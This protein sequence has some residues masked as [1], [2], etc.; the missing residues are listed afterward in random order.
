[1]TLKGT[2]IVFTLSGGSN[3]TNPTMSWGGDPS[4]TPVS[5]S[6][7]NLFPDV[8]SDQ[9]QNGLVDYSCFYVFNNS[10]AD[11]L[12]NANV[13]VSTVVQ[14]GS[15]VMIGIPVVNEIQTVTLTGPYP[16]SGSFVLSIGGHN[17]SVNQNNDLSVWAA[18]FQAAIRAL[19]NDMTDVVVTAGQI[20]STIVFTVFF[21]GDAGNTSQPLLELIQNNLG[22]GISFAFAK[23]QVGSPINLITTSIE[24]ATTAPSGIAFSFPTSSHPISIGDLGPTE[25][26]PV[27]V[28][29]T[30]PANT[31]ALSTDGFSLELQGEATG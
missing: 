27:W 28:Q 14:G 1:M 26:F 30:T 8:T 3:N 24:T 21:D 12:Y 25:G 19:P 9:A 7:N 31:A 17:F 18:N 13:W 10:L 5:Q 16:G 22:P 4:S 23:Q 11:T 29:R 15:T 20:G 6:L 2:D